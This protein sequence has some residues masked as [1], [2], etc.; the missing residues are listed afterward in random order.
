ML[1]VPDFSE[2]AESNSE[3]IPA[4]IYKVRLEEATPVKTKD[5]TG[6]YI[7]WKAKIFGAEGE[8]EKYNN[9]PVFYNTMTSGKGAGMLKTLIAAAIG[10]VPEGNFDTD[11]LLGKEVQFTLTQGKDKDGNPSTWPNVKGVRAITQ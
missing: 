9:W 10:E 11:D 6:T 4:G 1:V 7:K 2:A 3:P 8:L 5:G